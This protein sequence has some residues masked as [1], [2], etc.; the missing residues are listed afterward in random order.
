M[1]QRG[2]AK[3]VRAAVTD[4]TLPAKLPKTLRS[5]VKAK[6]A[7]ADPLKDFVSRYEGGKRAVYGLL[8]NCSDDD[9]AVKI[10][11]EWARL[12][13]R[14]KGGTVFNVDLHELLDNLDMAPRDFVGVVSRCGYDFGV[15]AARGIFASRYPQMMDA[16]MRRA[17]ENDATDERAIHFK[18]TGHLPTPQGLRIAIQQNNASE[19]EPEPGEAPAVGR[20]AR[21]VVRDLPPA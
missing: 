6:S 17:M 2:R 11:T 13:N 15:S 20:T 9:E 16:S 12:I 1:A 7:L 4:P 5:L 14:G 8:L 19:R 10:A 21:R 3:E 18:A